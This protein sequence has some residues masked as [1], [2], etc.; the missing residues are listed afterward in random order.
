MTVFH[1]YFYI[2]VDKQR[3][4][5]TLKLGMANLKPLYKFREQDRSPT[6]DIFQAVI[7]CFPFTT[8]P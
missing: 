3:G 1:T 8:K 7:K 4:Y 5:H 2:V 6:L